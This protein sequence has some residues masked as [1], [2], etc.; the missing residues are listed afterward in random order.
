MCGRRSLGCAPGGTIACCRA[1]LSL[2]LARR[3]SGKFAVAFMESGAEKEYFLAS[4]CDEVYLPPSAQFSLKG[5]SVA[6][7]IRCTRS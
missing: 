5:F 1:L 2:R 6:G 3:K 7:A 4:A